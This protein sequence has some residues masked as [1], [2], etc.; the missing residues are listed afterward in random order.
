M[1]GSAVSRCIP[2]LAIGQMV[3]L[4]SRLL[5]ECPGS[6]SKGSADTSSVLNTVSDK[7]CGSL[8]VARK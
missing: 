8:K 2:A 6:P 3:L 1:D 4:R 7:L 5:P